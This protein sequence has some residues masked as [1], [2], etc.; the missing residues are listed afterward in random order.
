MG[1]V[2]FPH[3]F[4]RQVARAAVT[5]EKPKRHHYVGC[6]SEQM[7][8]NPQSANC[9]SFEISTSKEFRSSSLILFAIDGISVLAS[10]AV[11]G[12]RFAKITH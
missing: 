2:A 4:S 12:H 7:N 1:S 9:L 11:S 8:R 10:S 3:I 6:Q 5:S